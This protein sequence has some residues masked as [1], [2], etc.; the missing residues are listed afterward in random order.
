MVNDRKCYQ[1]REWT[2]NCSA[3]KYTARHIY[4]VAKVWNNNGVETAKVRTD[5]TEICQRHSLIRN[6]EETF[7]VLGIHKILITTTIKLAIM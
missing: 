4:V 1:K 7:L 5:K 6:E 3:K 2:S